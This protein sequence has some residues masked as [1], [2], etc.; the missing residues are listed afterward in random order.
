MKTS[1][2]EVQMDDKCFLS[3]HA[4]LLLFWSFLL[5][6]LSESVHMSYLACVYGHMAHAYLSPPVCVYLSVCHT[7]TQ[8]PTQ[9][10]SPTCWSRCLSCPL[11][12]SA[13]AASSAVLICSISVTQIGTNQSLNQNYRFS[14][15]SY[16][17]KAADKNSA[18]SENTH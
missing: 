17:D 13:L 11:V 18:G 4:S 8:T 12:S 7:H 9:T 6:Y 5:H 16:A 3:L 1:G 15:C 14:S 2:C 10:H